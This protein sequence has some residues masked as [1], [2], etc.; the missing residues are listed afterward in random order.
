VR[1]TKAVNLKQCKKLDPSQSIAEASM[2]V[3]LA[4]TLPV[5]VFIM[6]QN[7]IESGGELDSTGVKRLQRHVERSA[8][9]KIVE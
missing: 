3:G 5:M 9:R 2:A 7:Q 4:L 8:T 1:A 6:M